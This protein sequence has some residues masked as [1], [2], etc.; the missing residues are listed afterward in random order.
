[1][2]TYTA[3]ICLQDLKIKFVLI[4]ILRDETMSCGRRKRRHIT[5]NLRFLPLHDMCTEQLEN[6]FV[7]EH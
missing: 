2:E 3:L 6:S 7:S 1:V 4:G 5:T